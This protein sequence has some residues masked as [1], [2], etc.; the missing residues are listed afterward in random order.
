MQAVSARIT[1]TLVESNI[2]RN[3]LYNRAKRT[4]VVAKSMQIFTSLTRLSK[5]IRKC[6][7]NPHCFHEKMQYNNR[8]NASVLPIKCIKTVI[9]WSVN[10]IVIA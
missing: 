6:T 7:L 3:T 5:I 9:V 10:V 4:I 8:K 1:H 2:A